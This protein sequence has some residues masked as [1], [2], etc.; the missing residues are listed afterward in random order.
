MDKLDIL[1]NLVEN[2]CYAEENESIMSSIDQLSI[3]DDSDDGSIS[4]KE[5]KEI[6][7][8]SQ[9]IQRLPQEMLDLK[10]VTVFNKQ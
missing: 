9:L 8:G 7:Y 2:G 3:D 6:R 5:L 1:Q 4:I 10:Y